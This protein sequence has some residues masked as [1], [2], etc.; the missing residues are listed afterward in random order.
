MKRFS[1]SVTV[2]AGAVALAACGSPPM[3]TGASLDGSSDAP[4]VF[5]SSRSPRAIARCLS[6]RLSHVDERNGAGF[7][8]LG[9][10]HSSNGYA[11]LV[12]LAPT[13]VGSNVRVE[14]ALDDDSV[15]EPALRFAIARCTA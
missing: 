8:E 3:T 9:I 5:S 14:K 13:A 4:M 12:T 1:L 11:W 15:S 6:G 7:T 10:G 2:L